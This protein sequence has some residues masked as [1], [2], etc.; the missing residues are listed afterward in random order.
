[1]TV[2]NIEQVNWFDLSTAEM[3]LILI[4]YTKTKKKYFLLSQKHNFLASAKILKSMNFM[5]MFASI[6][7]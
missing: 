2:L 1:M 5:R 4:F 6:L 7:I 3:F